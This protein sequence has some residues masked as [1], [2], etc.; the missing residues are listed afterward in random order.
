[1]EGK[2]SRGVVGLESPDP[3]LSLL[4][5]LGLGIAAGTALVVDRIGEVETARTLADLSEDG[6]S[7]VELAP[8]RAGVAV[9]GDGGVGEAEARQVIASLGSFWPAVIVRTPPDAWDGPTIPVRPLLPGLLAP[10][11][12]RPAVWQS[13]G[14]AVSPPGPGPVL[15]RPSSRLVAALLGGRVPFRGRWM[16]GWERVWEMP[17][18]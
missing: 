7:S 8:G 10:R 6:P 16:R 11:D 13:C 5:C 9:I 15:P 17:W 1:V 12:A 2:I 18:A 14:A 4:G 3:V